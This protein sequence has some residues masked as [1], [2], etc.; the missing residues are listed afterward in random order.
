MRKAA[1]G[2]A[3]PPRTGDRLPLR[4]GGSAGEGGSR[5]APRAR[6]WALR[7]GGV[8]EDRR[9]RIERKRERKREG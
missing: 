4:I 6:K 5:L 3:S 7:D 9:R 2:A 8:G 1:S